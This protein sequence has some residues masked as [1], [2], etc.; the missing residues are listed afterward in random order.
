MGTVNIGNI[1]SDTWSEG[2]TRYVNSS[3]PDITQFNIDQEQ[4]LNLALFDI[5]EGSDADLYLYEDTNSNN[6]Y[7]QGVDQQITSSWK[8]GN[9]DESINVVA[10]PGTYFSVVQR[11]SGPTSVQY[12]IAISATEQNPWPVGE[13]PNLLPT[14][15]DSGT[16][17]RGDVL[18]QSGWV[19]NTNTSDIYEFVTGTYG[20]ID[21]DLTGLSSDADLRVIFDSDNDKIVDPGEWGA[22]TST[23]GGSANEHISVNL[24]YADIPFYVQVYQYSGETNYDLSVTMA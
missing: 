20:S 6:Q 4:S 8:G 2:Q 10:D 5:P 22:F 23:N 16:L 18:T 13:A 14:E 19:G 11:Y 21:I 9:L 15:V 1:T 24:G 17:S 12:K 7:D 3:D